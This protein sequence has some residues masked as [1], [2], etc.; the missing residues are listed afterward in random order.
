MD[1]RAAAETDSAEARV[2]ISE[3]DSLSHFRRWLTRM[4]K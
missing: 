2:E 4:Q 3:K 1:P